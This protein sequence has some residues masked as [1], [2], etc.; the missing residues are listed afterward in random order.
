VISRPTT[1]QVLLDCCR[2]LEHDVLPG[3]ADETMRVRVVMLG[4]VLRNAAVRAAHEV[5]WMCEE[6]A[7]I[8]AYARAVAASA[9]SDGLRAA[10]DDLAAGPRDSL[11]LADVVEL[12]VR[13]SEVL[14]VAL[15]A[16][17][18]NGADELVRQGEFLLSARL[19]HENDVVG[20][21]NSVGR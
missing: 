17:L 4:K 5:A 7:Q 12:Y 6:T 19:G 11:H 20:G 2:V 15:E 9:G 1:E 13:A 10:L 14:S 3:L 8:E 21:W 18:A 16:A